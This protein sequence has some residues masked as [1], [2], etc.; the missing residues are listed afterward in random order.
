MRTI[1]DNAES[2]I[3]PAIIEAKDQADKDQTEAYK[4]LFEARQAQEN[5][6][7]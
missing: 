7:E 3:D 5:S 6:A 1:Y 4:R 2:Q